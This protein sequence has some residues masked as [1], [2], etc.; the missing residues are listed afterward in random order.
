V[1]KLSA[2]EK[3]LLLGLLHIAEA[4][5]RNDDGGGEGDYQEWTEE[6]FGRLRRMEEFINDLP[7]LRPFTPKWGKKQ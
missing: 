2:R 5:S 4:Q 6:D 1:R 7:T 3:H